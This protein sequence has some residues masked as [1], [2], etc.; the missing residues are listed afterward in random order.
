[1]S[2]NID[3]NFNFN[4][5]PYNMIKHPLPLSTPPLPPSTISSFAAIDVD[6]NAKKHHDTSRMSKATPATQ[7]KTNEVEEKKTKNLNWRI[8]EDQML[9]I[10]CLNTSKDANVGTGQ[11]ASAFWEHIHNLFLEK[12]DKIYIQDHKNNPKFKPFPN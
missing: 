11:K 4:L 3:P 2:N 1:M 7:T 8:E 5:H 10:S 12:M 6:T 9:C